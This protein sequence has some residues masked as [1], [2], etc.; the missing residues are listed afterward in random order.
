MRIIKVPSLP[1]VE[2]INDI[3]KALKTTSYKNYNE[4]IL[5]LPPKIGT[6]SIRGIN[7]EGG[8][9]IIQYDCTFKTDT[10]IQ[11]VLNEIH[12]L[13][14]LYVLSGN[15]FHRFSNEDITHTVD[16]Y[17]NAIVASS[18][19]NG[20]ILNFKKDVQTSVFSVEI[21]RERFQ[22]KTK[23]YD[24]V[25]NPKLK[26]LFE[27]VKAKESFYYEG[28]YIL[29]MADLFKKIEQFTDSDFLHAIFMEGIAYQTL[30][31][32]ITQFIDDQNDEGNRT[33][34]RRK[35]L[36]GIVKASLY[37]DKNLATYKL[38]GTLT[39]LTGLNEAKL[40]EGFRHLYK[41]T[42]NQYVSDARLELAKKLLENS[43]D[44]V[45][46]IVYK[47]GLSS[48]SHFSR[49]FKEYFGMQPSSFRKKK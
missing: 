43:E 38:L 27:D 9:G 17:Q 6:G 40:Q 15:L 37:I 35:E 26:R 30:V 33:V 22:K 29:K 31:L 47:V 4:Q 49:I 10:E 7:F 8:M 25:L 32:Q 19:G 34:L 45:S 42:V 16:Q 24:D 13:K 36:E 1:L 3:A 20:H 41:K 5:N 18:V 44:S 14:F 2:V 28:E 12:P 23:D 46:E 21:N 11:F 39:K 48:R